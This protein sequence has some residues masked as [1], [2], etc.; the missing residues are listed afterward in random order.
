MNHLVDPPVHALDEK[1]N[2]RVIKARHDLHNTIAHVLGFSEMLLEDARKDGLH[3]LCP[4]L[5]R[6]VQTGE[7]MIAHVNENLVTSKV[8][9]GLANLPRLERL[10]SNWASQVVASVELLGHSSSTRTDKAFQMDLERIA[11]AAQ[12]T[13]ELARTSLP[14][15]TSDVAGETVFLKQAINPLL[16]LL[17]DRASTTTF[18]QARKQGS[19]LIIDDM[20]ENRELL[21]RRLGR[22]GYSVEV[23]PNGEQA[24]VTISR[25]AP[26]LIL[27]DILMPELDGFEVLRRLKADPLTQH[28]PVIMLSSA[29]ET[30]TAVRCIE[31][32]ADDFLPKPFN[33]TLL[34]ARIE[35]SLAKKRLR[36]QEG[37][38]LKHIR[39]ERDISDRLLLNIL[40]HPIADRLKQG[41]KVIADNFSEVTVLF[42]DF[43]GFTKFAS[44]TSPAALVTRLNEIFSSFDELCDT[45]GL[46][47][48]KMIGDAYMAVAG[49]PAPRS[50][51]AEAAANLALDMQHETARLSALHEKPLRMRIGLSTGPV[52]AGV[53]GSKKFAYDLWGDTVNLASRMESHAETGSILVSQTTYERL[54]DKYIFR[55]ARVIRA[56]GKGQIKGYKLASRNAQDK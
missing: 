34:M 31:L 5:E 35:S 11:L 21:S 36:D 27:L 22:L 24:L 29:D 4:K 17:P 2:M 55:P 52:V 43:V 56:K 20:E 15:L 50:D 40:P 54:K 19:I 48:I 9:G 53:I 42:S 18:I 23:T 25:H 8:E 12:K 39:A 6:L 26:D 46:E 3:N 33:P 1:L 10:L 14:H 16:E 38:F 41:E 32:G 13:R 44:A 28:I 45:H 49:I 7:E 37:E 47:K 30:E 51:H